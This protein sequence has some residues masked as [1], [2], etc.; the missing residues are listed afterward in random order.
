MLVPGALNTLMLKSSPTFLN[1]TTFAADG[2]FVV[3][4][5]VT[6]IRIKA[7]GAGGDT[8]TTAGG[9]GGFGGG[10][11]AVIP[12]E[13][14][15]VKIGG[16]G[17]GLVGGANGGGGGGAAVLINGFGGGG[18]SGVFRST[19]NQA[20]ALVMGAGGGGG[21]SF[22]TT[23]TGG[24]GGGA[25]GQAGQSGS[26]GQ[27]GTQVAGGA[28]GGGVGVGTA[29]QGGIGDNVSNNGGG[30]GGG[31]YFGGGGGGSGT[32][33]GPAGGGGS[34]FTR[35]TN[36]NPLLVTAV[37]GAVANSGDPDYLIGKGNSTQPGYLVV[38]Y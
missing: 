31:G 7:W 22:N 4:A 12:G 20:G 19:V 25:I 21:M 26:A 13:T 8:G 5:G 2:N 9:G 1:V 10:D 37:N 11:V 15:T 14:L 27:G 32:G 30:G 28:A 36:A 18:Y 34:G 23:G 38:R 24:G 33:I 3:P 17:L 16:P 35:V 6:T 29:L